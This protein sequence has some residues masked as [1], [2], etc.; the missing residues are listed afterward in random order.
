MR[1]KGFPSIFLFFRMR[2]FSYY[3]SRSGL[4]SSSPL[5]TSPQIASFKPHGRGM[6]VVI[7]SLS[8]SLYFLLLVLPVREIL[9]ICRVC[10]VITYVTIGKRPPTRCTMLSAK[11]WTKFVN[12]LKRCSKVV[13]REILPLLLAGWASRKGWGS[14]ACFPRTMVKTLLHWS[15]MWTRM[16]GPSF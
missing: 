10:W 13:V 11:V 9:R 2:V 15:W 14:S 6:I 1:P 12:S 5:T 4:S 16:S 7:A 8:G 3:R